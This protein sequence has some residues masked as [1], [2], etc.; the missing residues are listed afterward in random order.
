MVILNAS[1]VQDDA[2]SLD[3]V[4]T[5]KEKPQQDAGGLPRHA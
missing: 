1:D 4:D 3:E 5:R 2:G